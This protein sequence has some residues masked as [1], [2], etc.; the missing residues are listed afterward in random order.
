MPPHYALITRMFFTMLINTPH[1]CILRDTQGLRHEAHAASSG[2]NPASRG[3]KASSI[4]SRGECYCTTFVSMAGIWRFSFRFFPSLFG[5]LKSIDLKEKN[6]TSG[7][8][9]CSLCQLATR[10]D[11][12]WEEW[13]L[14]EAWC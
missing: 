6:D 2:V 11:G 10:G 12:C 7:S 3:N 1:N 5:P 9:E 13:E 14:W 4:S 8:L